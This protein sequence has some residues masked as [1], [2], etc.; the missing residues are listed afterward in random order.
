M[1]NDLFNEKQETFFAQNVKPFV[2]V[3]NLPEILAPLLTIA[4]NLWWCWNSDAVELFRRMDRDLWEETYHNPRAML[5]MVNQKRLIELSQDNSFVSHMERVKSELEKYM[6]MNTWYA[7]SCKEHQ[8]MQFAYFSTE[9]AIHESIPIYSGGLGV[10]SGD[11]L[12]SASDLGLPL[13]GVGILYRY[14]YFKQYLTFDGWQQ[15]EYSENHFTRMPLQPVKNEDG[16]YLIIDI[17]TP[18]QK[19]YARVWK[20]QV[21]RVPLYLLDT[22]FNKNPADVRKITGQLYGGD[23]EMR[24]LQEII[25]GMGGIKLLKAL[26]LDPDIIHINE[27]H[28]AFLL[29]EKMKEYIEEN[30]LSAEEAFHMVKNGCVFTTHTPV[31]A[32]NEMFTTD[33]FL[34]YFEAMSKKM[35]IKKENFLALGSFPVKELTVNA[36]QPNFSMTILALRMSNKANGVSRLHATV[37][38]EMWS[39]LWPEI[40]RKE[41]PITHITNGIHTNTWISYEFAELFD[42]YLGASWKDEPADH[43][44]W[45]RVTQIP[46][47]EIWRSHERRK[48]R[49]VSFARARLRQQL[50]RRGASQQMISYADEVLDPEAL[51]IGFARRFAAYKRGDL[52]FKDL[53][54]IKKILTNKDFPVQIIIAG[55]SHP[56]DNIG[57][58]IIKKIVNMASDP[59]LRY[60]VVFL[61]DYDMNVAH[62]LVQGADIWLNNPLRPEEASGTS[63]MKAAVNG[64]INF[65]VLDGWW[66]EGYNGENGWTIG[67]IDR[68]PDKEYQD[69]VESKAIYETLEKEIIPLY[70]AR[71]TDGIPRDWIKKMKLSMKTLGPVFNTNRMVEEY[72][73]KFYIPTALAHEKLKKDGFAEAKK[74]A[75]WS[76]NIR[77]NWDSVKIVFSDDNVKDEIK[78]SNTLTVQAKV[79]LGL[80]VPDDVSVQIYSG[81]LDSKQ[82]VSEQE[83]DEMRLVSK[84]GDFYIYEGKVLTDKVGHCGYTV[85]VLPQY[86]GEIQYIPRAVKWQQNI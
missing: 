54:R 47:A 31:P 34:K 64:V 82:V 13:V 6:N 73:R 35:G 43:S 12:K 45:N 21:G 59:E 46:D 4:N 33:L 79:D 81:Y 66:C 40:P 30:G 25:L 11:H 16:T 37:A 72:V 65:S 71:R 80:L 69:E 1:N 68:Y 26:K 86:S 49:L 27:G 53:E 55:K 58:E 20:L 7:D 24:I 44:L 74:K 84:E 70:Y 17:D 75:V 57:K 83:I 18:K 52:I 51:T 8:N 56:Q 3:P 23:R 14:G 77:K 2:V 85:R 61:E 48:E 78:I 22:D 67:S 19:I 63:G 29:F 42:R 9:F 5:G 39:G 76:E 28:S 38:R 62:Y 50:E 41:V 10:L 15:E 60:K 32:G 36:E